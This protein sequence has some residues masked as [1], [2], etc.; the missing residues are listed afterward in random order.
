MRISICVGNYAKTPYCIPGLEISVFCVEELCYCMKENA[1]LLDISVMNDELMEWLDKECGLRDLMRSLYPLV[2]KK[3]SLSSFVVTIMRYVGLYEEDIILETEKVLKQGAGL[4]NIEK[5]K[6]QIDLLVKKKKYMAAI[7]DY[8]AL[9]GKWQELENVGEALPAADCLATIWNN[10]GVACTGMML[11]KEASQ[12]FLTAYGISSKKEYYRSYLAAKRMELSEQKYIDFAADCAEHYE[13]ALQLEKDVERTLEE[14]EQ[15]P[16]YMMLYHMREREGLMDR[17]G[18]L[19]ERD[20]LI[21]NLINCYRDY[22]G[23]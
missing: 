11:Y 23:N 13:E 1:F 17:Q 19:Q 10:K 14:W 21:R 18:Y 5:R 9:I 3:G 7:G 6:N 4:S 8:E 20:K 22:A 16:D 15:Q 12:C 2:H